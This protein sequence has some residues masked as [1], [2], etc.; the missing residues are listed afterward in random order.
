MGLSLRRQR[1][2]SPFQGHSKVGGRPEGRAVPKPRRRLAARRR[3][4]QGYDAV[5]RIP[6]GGFPAPQ[7]AAQE[8]GGQFREVDREGA[9]F[10][11]KQGR[12]LSAWLVRSRLG[13]L[14]RFRAKWLPVRVKK[15][16]QNKNPELRF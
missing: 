5:Q 3:F 11:Q 13:R 6:V 15:T 12:G 16:R 8:R 1:R 4:C 14:E 10:C 7:I 9:G 2:T